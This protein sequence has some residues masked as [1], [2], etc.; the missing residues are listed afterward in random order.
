MS[1]VVICVMIAMP[2]LVDALLPKMLLPELRLGSGFA[3]SCAF[4]P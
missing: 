3:F 1:N 2:S 4:G